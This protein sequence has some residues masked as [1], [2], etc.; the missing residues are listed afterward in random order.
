MNKKGSMF[1]ALILAILIAM[2][3]VS[4]IGVSA[5]D[6][7]EDTGVTIERLSVLGRSSPV[8]VASNPAPLDVGE[9]TPFVRGVQRRSQQSFAAT[10]E[11]AGQ[12]VVWSVE[13]ATDPAT[14]INSNGVLT[15]GPDELEDP[16]NVTG[17]GGHLIIKATSVDNPSKSG[18]TTIRVAST[19]PK[20]PAANPYL[21]M[22]ERIPD[23]EPRVFDDPDNPG[24][25]RVYVYGSLDDLEQSSY[26]GWIHVT[27]SAPVEDLSDWRYDGL[28]FDKSW[29]NGKSIAGTGGTGAYANN[30]AENLY[31]PD[32]IYNP[33]TKRYY[34]YSF[35]VTSSGTPRVWVSESSRPDGPFSENVRASNVGYH[36]NAAISNANLPPNFQG[37]ARNSGGTHPGPFDIAAWVEEDDTVE[38]GYR[39]WAYFGFQHPYVAE[40]EPDM[41]TM[42]IDTV[43]GGTALLTGTGNGYFEAP[44][45]RK[46]DDTYL[47]IYS[48]GASLRYGTAT[49]PWG[50]FTYQGIMHD[51]ASPNWSGSN[52]HG[53]IAEINGK[54]YIFGHRHA[55]TQGNASGVGMLNQ[56]TNSRRQ[57]VVEPI[58]RTD[59]GMTPGVVR[60]SQ[61]GYTS[62]GFAAAEGLDPFAK[63]DA[64][65]AS[66][67]SATGANGAYIQSRNFGNA[68]ERAWK[69]YN[70]MA[71]YTDD[72]T[73]VPNINWN[74]LVI[75]GNS[76]RVGYRNYNFG[77]GI[78]GNLKLRLTVRGATAANGRT[79]NVEVGPAQTGGNTVTG[80][81]TVGSA[82]FSGLNGAAGVTGSSDTVVLDIPIT[83]NLDQLAGQKSLYLQC[84]AGTAVE[85]NSLQFI[86]GP[87]LEDVSTSAEYAMR[88]AVP[89]TEVVEG[90]MLIIAQYNSA[91]ALVKV[92]LTDVATAPQIFSVARDSAAVSAKAF[93]WDRNFIPLVTD[94]V[95]K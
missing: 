46:V 28:I 55:G 2:S 7:P 93:Q 31:A 94:I 59:D 60:F 75:G 71:E 5:N 77:D 49:V 8:W 22:W 67:R 84:P 72:P 62:A 12:D 35:L 90:S 26:C 89:S 13:G 27:W 51:T 74:P 4:T 68:G 18:T 3:A 32:V 78:S 10:V 41:S 82:T 40:L 73:I 66:Y 38:C 36:N 53:S 83:Q 6:L 80:L 33:V 29:C 39:V 16:W 14:T 56:P 42:K 17:T 88:Y 43:R 76:V 70:G 64:G 52:N 37:T 81:V 25:K 15:V 21:P 69:A 24:K 47:F 87:P 44:S 54:Y 23:G 57:A 86:F 65:I 1:L 19:V 30:T 61:A 45:M 91:G 34:L 95:L 79:V 9:P 20:T 50:P 92:E 63:Y 11:G 48:A 58:T 85:I